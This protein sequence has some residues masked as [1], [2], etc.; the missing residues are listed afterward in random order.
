MQISSFPLFQI[1]AFV[2]VSVCSFYVASKSNNLVD[3]IKHLKRNFDTENKTN[4]YDNSKI[5]AEEET[6]RRTNKHVIRKDNVGFKKLNEDGMHNQIANLS[7]TLTDETPCERRKFIVYRCRKNEYCNGWGGRQKGFIS[8]Y[9][10]A[11]LTK[12]YFIII[13]NKACN[14]DTYLVPNRYNWTKC[15]DYVLNLLES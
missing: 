12:R 1:V 7:P 9:L 4:S 13:H 2:C 3:I 5:A 11:L 8:T 6:S 15:S 10:M 14:L